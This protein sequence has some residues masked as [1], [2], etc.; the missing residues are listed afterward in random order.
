VLTMD[1]V[2]ACPG[3]GSLTPSPPIIWQISLPGPTPT[4]PDPQYHELVPVG[5]TTRGLTRPGV[6]RLRLPHTLPEF[7]VFTPASLDLAGTDDQPPIIANADQAKNVIYWLRAFRP[8]VNGL[9][10]NLGSALWVGVNATEVVQAT[11]ASPEFLGTGTA[12]PDQRYRLINR[13]VVPGSLVVEV[14]EPDGWRPWTEVD[15]FQAS[16]EWDRH[17][18]VDA[19]SG[20]VRF[21]NGVQGLVPQLG[22]RIRATT[23]RYGGG[24]VGNV[25]AGAITQLVTATT[26]KSK[27]PLAARGGADSEAIADALTRIPGE[28][29]RHDRAVCASDFQELALATPG[30]DVGR[31]EVLPLFFPPKPD[32]DPAAGVVSVVV[33]PREDRRHPNA[34]LPDRSLLNAVCKYLDARRLV[35]TEL[36]VIP[37]TYKQIAV[38]I[39]LSAKDGYGIEA[40]RRWV[41]LAVRQF[42]A[43]LPPYGPT[44]TGWPLGRRVRAAEIEAAALQ[45]EGVEFLEGVTLASRDSDTSPWV[46]IDTCPTAAVPVPSIE[47]KKWQVV[48][49]A[50]LTVVQGPPLAAGDVPVPPP[51]TQPP[52]PVPTI[53]EEC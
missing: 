33:W 35:T 11:T 4:Q 38:G 8:L 19:E 13:Q 43:P 21:G 50:S 2:D 23:Y 3:A 34:P 48:E 40:V 20:E 28:F 46:P 39:G 10:P 14:E 32:L 25:A 52:V 29:R 7:G 16:H 27:N 49:L 31:A 5:D 53:Q 37:P 26:V 18:L 1:Q 42:L 17:F 30:A 41:E 15:G 45:V 12:Q 22:E 44:G 51:M 9:R 47:L 6:V 24:T 36:Y